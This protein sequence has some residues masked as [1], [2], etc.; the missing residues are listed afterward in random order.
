MNG[1]EIET[2]GD[3][4]AFFGATFDGNGHV[5]RNVTISKPNDNRV[6]IFGRIQS[7]CTIRNL[8]IDQASITGYTYVGVL[9]GETSTEA[10]NIENCFVINSSVTS[11]YTSDTYAGII[12]GNYWSIV[13]YSGNCYCLTIDETEEVDPE[14]QLSRKSVWD[15]DD[16]DW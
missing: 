12:S 5:I 15:D 7:A 11:N 2:I 14:E 6:G 3:N 9:V 1:I 16:A 13:N 4:D 10:G 8:I